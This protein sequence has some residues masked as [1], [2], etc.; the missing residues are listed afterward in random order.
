MLAQKYTNVI[1]NS[2]EENGLLKNYMMN[3]KYFTGKILS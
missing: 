1:L 3:D 2:V